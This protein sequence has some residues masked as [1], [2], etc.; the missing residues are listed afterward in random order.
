MLRSTKLHWRFG[1]VPHPAVGSTA[2]RRKVADRDRQYKDMLEA[3]QNDTPQ[4][5]VAWLNAGGGERLNSNMFQCYSRECFESNYR[6][7]VI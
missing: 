7:L 4:V 2:R 5:L 6:M 3:V 1:K